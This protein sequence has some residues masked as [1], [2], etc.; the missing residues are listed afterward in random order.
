MLPPIDPVP[1]FTFPAPYCNSTLS[2]KKTGIC[3]KLKEPAMGGLMLRPFQLTL[4]PRK[5][6][7]AKAP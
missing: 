2:V 7:V 6:E 5:E 1:F 3:E 4:V